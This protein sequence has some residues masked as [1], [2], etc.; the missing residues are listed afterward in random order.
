MRG[1]LHLSRQD[2]LIFNKYQ[3]DRRIVKEGQVR[4]LVKLCV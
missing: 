1:E 4:G 3:I 2:I